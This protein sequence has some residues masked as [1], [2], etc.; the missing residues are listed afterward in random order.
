LQHDEDYCRPAVGYSSP[1]QDVCEQMTADAADVDVT[2]AYY[3]DQIHNATNGTAWMIG[4]DQVAWI[5]MRDDTCRVGPDPLGCRIRVSRERTNVIIHRGPT[6][7]APHP[8][9]R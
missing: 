6:A 4:Q 5:A 1:S 2:A 8:P 9:H 7:P 3:L